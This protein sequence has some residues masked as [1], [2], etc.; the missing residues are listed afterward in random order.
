M[1]KVPRESV[2]RI[3]GEFDGVELGD[4]RRVVRLQKLVEKL[5]MH[6]SESLP[7]ALGSEAEIEA[8][9]R[10]AN[11]SRI[12]LDALLAPHI[13]KTAARARESGLV[14]AIHDTTACAC[15]HADPEEV[16]YLNT[17]KAGFYAHYVLAVAARQKRPLGVVHLETL[18]RETK[19]RSGRKGPRKRNLSGAETHKNENREFTRWGRGIDAAEVALKGVPVI[20]IGDRETDSFELHAANI[21][22]QRRFV[23]RLR[24]ETR[25]AQAPDGEKASIRELS[26][27]AEGILERDVELSSRRTKAELR[28]TRAHPTREARLAKLSFSAT[29][30]EIRP[31]NYLRAELPNPLTLNVVRVWEKAPPD[32]AAPVEWLLYTTEPVSTPEEVAAVVDIYRARWLI[33]ECNKALKSGCLIEDR[34][35]ESLQASRTMLAISLPIACEVLALRAASREKPDAPALTVLSQVQIDILRTIG[36]R[37]MSTEPTLREALLAVAGMGGH[38]KSNGDPGWL[39]LQRGMQRLTDYEVGWR[40]AKGL[41]EM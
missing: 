9:Y 12:D 25:N 10:F 22:A 18:T 3:V 37:P 15:P 6:P 29:E 1:I 33:E 40:A 17:G 8:A 26:S 32:N 38:L 23:F 19:P 27:R 36:T 34:E 16:G 2:R 41:P 20:H 24:L 30:V 7:R 28:G 13:A 21:A 5:A 14:L 11:N 4:A 35:F 39:V 31:P